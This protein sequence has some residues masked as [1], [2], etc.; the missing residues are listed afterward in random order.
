MGLPQIV[1]CCPDCWGSAGKPAG[2]VPSSLSPPPGTPARTHSSALNPF[3]GISALLPALGICQSAWASLTLAVSAARLSLLWSSCLSLYL[4]SVCLHL[5]GTCHMLGVCWVYPHLSLPVGYMSPSVCACWVCVPIYL[6]LLDTCPHLSMPVGF[7]SPFVSAC[8][9][10][11]PFCLCLLGSCPLLSLPVGFVWPSASACWVQVSGPLCVRYESRP[12]S[13]CWVRVSICLGLLDICC[14]HLCLLG[15]CPYPSLPFEDVYPPAPACW[16][17]VFICLHLLD[18]CPCLLGIS[19]YLSPHGGGCLCL[20]GTYLLVTGL[21]WGFPFA[22]PQGGWGGGQRAAL[23][24]WEGGEERGR[25]RGEGV[26]LELGNH[27][28]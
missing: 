23:R 2:C 16:M 24:H 9:V 12:A 25:E 18:A 20:L 1:D 13:P 8:W 17:P 15:T 11:V 28:L 7:M 27:R 6:C 21:T 22:G 5:V 14:F 4:M 3:L 19:L 10:C 26:D